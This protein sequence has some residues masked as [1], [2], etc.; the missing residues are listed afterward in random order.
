M[1]KPVDKE[2]GMPITGRFLVTGAGRGLGRAI[3]RKLVHAGVQVIAVARTTSDLEEL[4]REFP[5]SIEMWA[6]DV[7]DRRIVERIDELPALDGLV[8]NAGG[9]RPEPFVDVSAENLDYLLD[10]NVRSAFFVAQAAAR[11]MCKAGRGSIVNITS[12]MG[13]VGSPGRSVY[14]MTKHAIEGLT[15]AMALELA[16]KGIRVNAVAPTF[17][18]TPMTAPMLADAAFRQYVLD[19]IPIGRIGQPDEIASAVLFLLSN[20]ASLITGT[21]LLVDGGWTAQ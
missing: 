21:S 11:V 19:R 1:E 10:L 6:A 16:P 13:H 17:V 18:E 20:N 3:V 12:Q 7:T 15:K 4:A 9:N 2:C 8:N 14:C 5:N